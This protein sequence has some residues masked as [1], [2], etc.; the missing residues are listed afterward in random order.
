MIK[1]ALADNQQPEI[2]LIQMIVKTKNENTTN[3]IN[4][5]IHSLKRA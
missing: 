4:G 5:F 2:A 1:Y 3:N